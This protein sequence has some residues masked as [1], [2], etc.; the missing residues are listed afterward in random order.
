MTND[1]V[2]LYT[3]TNGNKEY[4][5]FLLED[6]PDQAKHMDSFL[7]NSTLHYVQLT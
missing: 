3:L 6:T 2:C 1:P 4:P 7:D 5:L